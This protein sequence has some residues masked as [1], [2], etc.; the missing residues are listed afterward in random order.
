M[1]GERYQSILEDHLLQFMDVH[2]CTHF[3]Q[4]RA[5]CHASKRIKTFLATQNFSV[6][7]WPGNSPDLNHIEN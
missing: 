7:D 5:P 1:N 4:D 3:R 6:I 2:G